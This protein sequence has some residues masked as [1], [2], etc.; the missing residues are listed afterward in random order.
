VIE[1]E[2]VIHEIV[3]EAPPEEVFAMFVDPERLV[4]WLGLS[5]TLEPR[6]GGL[7]RFEVVPGQFCEGRYVVVEPPDRLVFTWGWTD[8][9]MLPGPGSSSVQVTFRAA[10]EGTRLRLVHSDLA[11]SDGRL[12]HDDGWSRFLSRLTGTLQGDEA[13]PYPSESPQERLGALQH[14]KG[15][16]WR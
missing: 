10:E 7:F 8:P 15:E 13:S 3:L 5:A 4:R 9:A 16:P 6:P 1:G 11:T 14:V 12:L 2:L